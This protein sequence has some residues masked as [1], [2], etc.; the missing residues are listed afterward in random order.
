MDDLAALGDRSARDT[1]QDWTFEWIE[2]YRDGSGPG[3]TPELTG[4]RVI[5]WINNAVLLSAGQPDPNVEAFH[6]SLAQQTLF[7]AKRWS[8]TPPGLARIEALTGLIY[9]GLSLRGMEGQSHPGRQP[10]GNRH[11]ASAGCT[12]LPVRPSSRS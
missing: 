1:A 2:R 7:L 5:R 3:W 4:R 6:L 10:A 9:A 12:R 11:A 8:A